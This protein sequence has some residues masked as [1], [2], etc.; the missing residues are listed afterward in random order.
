MTA[1]SSQKDQ[2][3][4]LGCSPTPWIL[5]L[6]SRL[7]VRLSS[8]ALANGTVSSYSAVSCLLLGCRLE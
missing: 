3:T 1:P 5:L 2:Y 8:L 7:I 6:L 4:L